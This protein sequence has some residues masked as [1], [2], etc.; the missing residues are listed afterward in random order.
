MH[1]MMLAETEGGKAEIYPNFMW[2]PACLYV[3]YPLQRV[4]LWRLKDEFVRKFGRLPTTS[5]DDLS[6]MDVL[7]PAVVDHYVPYSG[8]IEYLRQL[9][10][11]NVVESK[12][13]E[14][15]ARVQTDLRELRKKR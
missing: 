2:L 13:K 14:T 15:G 10:G 9:Q 11:M 1:F 3:H 12:I 4:V 5:E 7:A 8:T 6:R